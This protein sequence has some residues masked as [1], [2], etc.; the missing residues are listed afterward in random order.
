MTCSETARA[1]TP[2][3]L[4]RLARELVGAGADRLDEAQPLRLRQEIVPPQA[5]DHQHV[6]LADPLLQRGSVAHLEAVDAGAAC[7]EALP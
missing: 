7:Q 3:A 5:G 1:L 4:A 6:G 2:R